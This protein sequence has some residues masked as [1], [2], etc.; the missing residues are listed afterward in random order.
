MEAGELSSSPRPP[1]PPPPLPLARDF[2]R[3]PQEAAS[4]F[5]RVFARGLPSLAGGACQASPALR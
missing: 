3:R 4:I 1:Y 2:P 5:D